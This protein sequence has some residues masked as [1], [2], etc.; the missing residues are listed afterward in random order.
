[1]TEFAPRPSP[2]RA[3]LVPSSLV[4]WLLGLCLTA[5]GSHWLHVNAQQTAQ[6]RFDRY[7][8]KLEDSVRTR[9]GN[10]LVGLKGL[11]STFIAQGHPL[12][13]QGFRTWVAERRVQDDFPGLRGLGFIERVPRDQLSAFIARERADHAPDFEVRTSGMARDLLV[14]KFIEPLAPNRVAWG[15][16]AGSE[17]VRRRAMQ[18]AI[19]SGQPTLSGRL[20]LLQDGRQRAGFLYFLPLYRPGLPT[21]T[22]AQ[23]QAALMGLLYAPLIVEELV[24]G[25]A[26]MADRLVDFE[27]FDHDAALGPQLLFD[28]GLHQGTEDSLLGPGVLREAQPFDVGGRRL[29][30]QTR[31]T[32]AFDADTRDFTPLWFAVAGALLSTLMAATVWLLGAGRVRAEE[33]ADR[34]TD[35]LKQAKDRAEHALR[36]SKALI[37]TLD[38][39]SQI[40]VTDPSG[41]ITEVNDAFCQ[42]TGYSREELIGANHRIINADH[43]DAFFWIDMW[44]TLSA[45]QPWHGEVCNRD[46]EGRLFWV[47]SIIAPF[48]GADGQIEKYIAI[49]QDITRS[50][51]MEHELKALTERFTLAI[52]GGND[53]LWD[54]ADVSQPDQWWSPQF[55]RLLGYQ[56]GD[57]AASLSTF[58]QLLHPD[59]RARTLQAIEQALREVVPFDVEHRMLTKGREYRWFRTRAKVYFDDA[60]AATRMA[61]SIQDVHEHWLAQAQAAERSEQM[62]AIFSLSPDAFVSFDSDEQVSYAS[63]AFSHLT[64]LSCSEVVGLSEAQLLQ[65]LMKLASQPVSVA[66]FA[67]LPHVPDGQGRQGHRDQDALAHHTILEMKHP[68]RRMLELRMHRGSGASVTQVLHLSDVTREIALDQMK[69]EFMSMAAHELR[70]PMSSIFGF[71]ELLLT[72]EL[73]PERQKDL[74]EKIHRQSDAMITIIIELLELSR[75]EARGS[76]E[77]KAE[78]VDLL[79]VVE[80]VVRDYQRPGERPRPL[81][82]PP[83]RPLWVMADPQKAQQAVLNVLSNAYKYSPQG[84]DVRIEFL[85]DH[86]SATGPRCG[87]RITDQGIGLTPEQLARMGERFFRADQSGNIPGTGLGVSI[88]QE[89]MALMEGEVLIQSEW[90]RGTE[91]T[92]WLPASRSDPG[93]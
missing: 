1:M 74:L 42:S 4:T 44:Q 69:S 59:D 86:A 55:Y 82:S 52:E 62:G 83:Q 79:E 45:G 76:K 65:A 39:Y 19:D 81:M 8:S 13:R 60:G 35:D 70:T 67:D 68:A 88:V 90:G 24:T 47:S 12:D 41:T 31:T 78:P 66:R 26:D 91:V 14:I 92:L 30:L 37:D 7:N 72:R 11:K 73:K 20:A 9:F 10:A 15:Y 58:K 54:W 3:F 32:P 89:I 48:V 28:L 71:T 63:P 40:S 46:K 80:H 50:K 33:L 5:G 93:S 16:D 29:S 56:P 18:Q 23:R 36:D 57:V 38:R 34:M 27:L 84:G 43:H 85:Q 21:Q 87:V 61:G 49:R 25:I 75:M 64:S 2:R 17:P 22:A 51:M 53:G 77:F 6:L